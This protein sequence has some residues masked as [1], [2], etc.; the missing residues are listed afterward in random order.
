M[1]RPRWTPARAILAG[2]LAAGV[3]DIAYAFV[4]W[5]L[6]GVAPVRIL[7]SVASGLLG[8][9]AYQGGAGAAVLGAGL[10]LLNA[11]LIAAVYVLAS[12]R[13]PDLAHRPALWGPLYGIGAY[14]VMNYVVIPLSAF[15][16][17]GGSPAPVVWITGV[18]VHML[19]IGLPIALAA[20]R[21]APGGN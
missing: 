10:H 9:S 18:L 6:R 21:A 7:Q 14:L 13:L 15:P 12:R 20:R 11:F 3:L 4:F 1:T 17:R 5:G 16:R 8:A 19:L 2:G